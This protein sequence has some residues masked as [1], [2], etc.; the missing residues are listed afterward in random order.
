MKLIENDKIKQQLSQNKM[1]LNI[2]NFLT[3][4]GQIPVLHKIKQ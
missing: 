3:Q 4:L 2:I 1:Q